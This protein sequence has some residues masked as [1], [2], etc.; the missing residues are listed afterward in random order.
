[1]PFRDV[2]SLLEEFLTGFEGIFD[3]KKQACLKAMI[4]NQNNDLSL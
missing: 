1:V 4:P 2:L 3:T